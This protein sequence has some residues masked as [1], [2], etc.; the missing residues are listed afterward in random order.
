MKNYP[1]YLEESFDMTIFKDKD[2]F[3]V[4][5]RLI[6]HLLPRIRQ[7]KYKVEDF[8]NSRYFK[9]IPRLLQRDV[10]NISN[11]KFVLF[12]LH[13]FGQLCPSYGKGIFDH[14]VFAGCFNLAVIPDNSFLIPYTCDLE[15]F[16]VRDD[17]NS[18][19]YPFSITLRATRNNT[20][21]PVHYD[22]VILVHTTDWILFSDKTICCP[23]NRISIESA[24]ECTLIFSLVIRQM[25]HQTQDN[26]ADEALDERM[27]SFGFNPS[28]Q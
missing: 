18:L 1:F 24:T 4:F 6:D 19:K 12:L 21:P 16:R 7:E 9:E 25:E 20:N 22:K 26:G 10:I 27:I 14:T 5:Y 3:E 15:R 17:K 2:P 28:Y 11:Q 13:A 8:P 23:K